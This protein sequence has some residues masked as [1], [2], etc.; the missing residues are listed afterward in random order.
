[1]VETAILA[2]TNVRMPGRSSERYGNGVR[3]R[4]CCGDVLRIVDG[5]RGYASLYDGR[6]RHS[7]VIPEGIRYRVTLAVESFQPT[8]TMFRFPG[9]CAPV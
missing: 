7:V 1:M 9:V 8:T 5:L 2:N 4:S 6:S 3:A